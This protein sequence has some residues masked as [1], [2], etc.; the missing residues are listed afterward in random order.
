MIAASFSLPDG[1]DAP[2]PDEL[3]HVSPDSLPR[4]FKV[5]G[6]E[7]DKIPRMTSHISEDEVP[8]FVAV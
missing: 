7:R 3:P 4:Y 2:S 8:Y 5:R 6:R 1:F